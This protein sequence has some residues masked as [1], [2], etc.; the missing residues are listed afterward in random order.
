M[1]TLLK[2]L[3]QTKVSSGPRLMAEE[4][5][6]QHTSSREPSGTISPQENHWYPDPARL[7]PNWLRQQQEFLKH[8]LALMLSCEPPPS[9]QDFLQEFR[10]SR[11]RDPRLDDLP[12]WRVLEL[13][14]N[15]A[16]INFHRTYLPALLS[17]VIRLAQQQHPPIHNDPLWS[18]TLG[19]Q[20]T[21]HGH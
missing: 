12:V 1:E 20:E 6:A 7:P 19:A 13:A 2:Y 9:V 21:H 17:L 14:P 8:A 11:H 15:P 18:A 3:A 10:V 16:N 5:P 4:A